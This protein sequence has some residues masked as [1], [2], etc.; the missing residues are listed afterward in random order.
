MSVPRVT[1]AGLEELAFFFFF[2]FFSQI[3]N[4]SKINVYLSREDEQEGKAKQR[5]HLSLGEGL[6]EFPGKKV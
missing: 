2:A 1:E 6:C 4:K 5:L 3:L